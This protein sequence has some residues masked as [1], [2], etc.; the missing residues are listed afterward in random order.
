LPCKHLIAAAKA[1]GKLSGAS[2]RSEEWY[3]VTV[4]EGYFLD[5]YIDAL[6]RIEVVTYLKLP[7]LKTLA[8][9]Q[10]VKASIERKQ[11]GRPKGS[12]RK[13]SNGEKPA[14]KQ[15]RCGN[16]GVLGHNAR[17]GSCPST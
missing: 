7:N 17:S 2:G 13:K 9:C 10:E 15:K 6:E 8:Y 16:C 14:K 3:G 5:T 12:K 11:P 4:H 1:K